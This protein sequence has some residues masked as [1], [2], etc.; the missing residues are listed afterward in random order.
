M[1]TELEYLELCRKVY[2]EKTGSEDED[3]IS[4]DKMIA[5]DFLGNESK[6]EFK[7]RIE[8]GEGLYCVA[9]RNL[10]ENEIT[11]VFRGSNSSFLD[12]D[13]DWL[14][15]NMNL[16]WNTHQIRRARELVWAAVNEYGNQSNYSF[17]GHSLG[18]KLAQALL[19]EA[20]EGEFGSDLSSHFKRAVIFN[21]A[22]THNGDLNEPQL[23]HA[24]EDYPVFHYILDGEILNTAVKGKHFGKQAVLPLSYED[25]NASNTLSRHS[26]FDMFKYYMSKDGDFSNDQVNGMNGN[27]NEILHG[28]NSSDTII[29]YGGNDTMYGEGG[30][31]VYKFFKGHGQD[32]ILESRDT[33]SKMDELI[34]YGYSYGETEI[35][36]PTTT[37]KYSVSRLVKIVF[38]GSTDSITLQYS[39]NSNNSVGCVE[40]VSFADIYTNKVIKTIDMKELIIGVLENYSPK[41]N[42]RNGLD[43][44][45]DSLYNPQ[46]AY[47]EPVILDLDGNANNNTVGIDDGGVHFDPGGAGFA[48]KTGWVNPEDGLLVRDINQ[49][50]IINNGS[51]L[52]GQ[53]TQLRD[54]SLAESGFEALLDL[55][56]NGDGIIN[57]LDTAFQQLSIW[58]DDSADGITDQGELTTLT[59]REITAFNLVDHGNLEW[60]DGTTGNFEVGQ[61]TYSTSDQTYH[62][63]I[64][65]SLKI[66][67]YDTVANEW[68]EEPEAIQLLP[69]VAGSGLLYT[70]HQ[71]MMR[72]ASGQLK[73]WVQQFQTETDLSVRNNLLDRMIYK[74]TGADQVEPDSRGGI[75]DA[76]KLVVIEK[77]YGVSQPGYV[78]PAETAGTI[79]EFYNDIKENVYAQLMAQTHLAFL[80]D[81]VSIVWG[82][83]KFVVDLSGVQTRLQSSLQG[84]SSDAKVQLGEFMRTAK[85]LYQAEAIGLNKLGSYFSSQN[86]EWAWIVESNLKSSIIGTSQGELLTG[87]EGDDAI[88]GGDGDDILSGIKGNDALFG[89]LGNDTYMIGKDSGT[90]QIYEEDATAGN[91][92]KILLGEGILPGNVKLSRDQ[93]DL[94]VSI[95]DS[96]NKINVR[97]FFKSEKQRI[98]S[99]VFTNGNIWDVD[100]ILNHA[101]TETSGTDQLDTFYG[102]S[103]NDKYRAGAGDDT[104]FGGAGYDTLM[105]EA[106]NDYLSGQSGNDTLDGGTGNDYLDG[107]VGNDTYIFGKGY[108]SDTIIDSD[109][110]E[111]NYD[112]VLFNAG[113]LP[114]EITIVRNGTNLELVVTGTSDKLKIINYFGATS[115]VVEALSFSNGTVWDYNYVLNNATTPAVGTVGVTLTGTSG[116]DVLQGGAGNDT[117]YAGGGN[118]VLDGGSGN[119]LL[120]GNEEG[121]GYSKDGSDTYIFGRG[122]GQDTLYDVGNVKN[123]DTIKLLLNPEEIDILQ[124]QLNL[125]IRIK[126]TEEQIT[127][128]SYF[129]N[130]NNKVERILF[131]NDTSWTQSELEAKVKIKGTEGNDTLVGNY[132]FDDRMYGYGGNDKLYGDGGND[133]LDGGSGDDELYGDQKSASAVYNKGYDTY[134]F[135]KGYGQDRIYDYI[136]NGDEIQLLVNPEEVE[137]LQSNLDYIFRII[138]TGETITVNKYFERGSNKIEGVKFLDGTVWSQVI[139]EDKVITK[140]TDGDDILNGVLSINDKIYGLEGND[141][142]FGNS[143]NDLLEGGSGVDSLYGDSGDDVLDGG[144]GDDMLYGNISSN[145]TNNSGDDT[146]VFGKGYGHDTIYCYTKTGDHVI[147]D[148]DILNGSKSNLDTIQLLINPEEIDVLQENNDLIIS[149]RDTEERLRVNSYFRDPS[150]KVEQVKFADGTVWTQKQL[151]SKV[152]TKGT[153]G[154]DTLYGVN[155]YVDWMYGLAGDDKLYGGSGSDILDGGIGNDLLYGN[156]DGKGA[157]NSG[158][159]TYVFGKG[160]GQDIIYDISNTSTGST[161]ST[162][163][164]TIQLLVNMEDIDV[165]RDNMNLIIRIKETNEKITVNGYFISSINKI[166]QV[167][168]LNGAIWTQQQLESRVIIEGTDNDDIINGINYN[169]DR[170]YGLAGNDKL[171][172]SGG[173]DVLDG[174]S[175][176]DLLYGDTDQSG[177]YYIGDDTYVF[178]KGYGQDRIY[179]EG[180]ANADIIQMLVNPQEVDVLQNNLDLMIRIKETGEKI[181]VD[182]NFASYMHKLEQVQFLDG[183]VWTQTQLETKVITEGTELNDILN[184]VN[185]FADWMYGLGG[186]DILYAS[187]GNDVLDGGEGND[188]LY[189]DKD[190]A[191]VSFNSSSDIYVFGKGY[192]QDRVFE[193]AY[194][195]IDT[196]RMLVN[197]DEVEVLKN[198]LDLV[199]RINETGEKITVDSYFSPNA[200]KIERVE[201]FDGTIW[202]Q[203]QLESKVITEGTEGNDTLYGGND[204]V[205]WMK[206]LAGNDTLYAGIGNDVLDGGSGDDLLYGDRLSSTS[207]YNANG[208]DTYVFGKG[209][210]QDI[211]YDKDSTT[212]YVDTIQMLVNPEEVDV[213]QDNLDLMIRIKETGEKIRVNSYFSSSSYKVER[214]T[215]ADGTVWTQTQL[216]SKVITEG[217]EGSDTLYGV[218]GYVD[219]MQGLAGDDVLYAGTGNDVLDGGSGDDK[220]YGDRLSATSSKNANGNDTYVFGK[221]YGQDTVYDYDSTTGYVDTIQ[222]LVNPEEVDVLQDNL[223]LMIRIKETGEKIR[224]NSYFSSLSYKVERV[225]F[226]DGTEWTQAQLESKVVP[227]TAAKNASLLKNNSNNGEKE[228]SSLAAISSQTEQLIQ[229]MSTFSAASDMDTSQSAS[230]KRYTELP[231]LTQSWTKI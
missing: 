146:Y 37:G 18:G 30:S 182:L 82:N 165:I 54:G 128:N 90:V 95:D 51:E 39:N 52:F 153:E 88:S 123:V 200:N 184:G 126:G 29:G 218:N 45:F 46:K 193:T 7:G 78:P 207:S 50:G 19:V 135:G 134:I 215:F 170:M 151:E 201:F 187:G 149:I 156:E 99:I 158:N 173:N 199:V 49:D 75:V 121:N 112:R 15:E 226:A 41:F 131:A 115:S 136:G 116:N 216:E 188:L 65:Y 152:M 205:D 141:S 224:V 162:D 43:D 9:M 160:Y 164:D 194:S 166:E 147:N 231:V 175:G 94:I 142:L 102:T 119:D 220:L 169:V 6:W 3:G 122:Y 97:N 4:K 133:V 120:Y 124:D 202:T 172:G 32:T 91:T 101:L 203:T 31:D 211:I 206:G 139:L 86:I 148:N 145:G 5:K 20:I 35:I 230:E 190:V 179:D 21:A 104:A 58:Q 212:G 127:V 181:I 10:A 117:L 27:Y 92:D 105:G 221:G 55:D 76:Q 11:F 137:L 209:Y 155:G 196:I 44:L 80:Y 93:N 60:P 70:F 77:Y 71:T 154:N 24:K 13:G 110:T 163:V 195:G 225:A 180:N 100:Y 67:P 12:P 157:A 2:P 36:F 61:A 186:D 1:V 89:G 178:G 114:N 83:D 129:E 57:E 118:D 103:L 73:L 198:N 42:V 111:G 84:G 174:G 130:K 214:V 185:N 223:D 40:K 26:R 69:D 167:H 17:T 125:V 56:E 213:L 189:G 63:M 66:A 192:G 138:E 204:Y 143:G 197:P 222:M 62:P 14:G 168:F 150:Y 228:S 113:L 79:I 108:G 159:D 191:G 98:E 59:E 171:Y 107:G 33:N 217:T 34:I 96:A 68:L 227:N 210:E 22:P 23:S 161:T 109:S 132:D 87:T 38:K 28:R 72:D 140:G 177:S 219:W 183:T 64:E 208:S 106:G 16:N 74:W 48:E 85:H 229:A 25:G 144:T 8:D 176:D 81:E 47:I 53:Y